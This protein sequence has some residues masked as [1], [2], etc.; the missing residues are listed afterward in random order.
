MQA[1]L[2]SVMCGTCAILACTT[3]ALAQNTAKDGPVLAARALE[4]TASFTFVLPA[5]SIRLVGWD[6]D[7]L[8]IRGS[9]KPHSFRYGAT[10]QGGK[11]FVEG[12]SQGTAEP[13]TVVVYFPRRGTVPVQTS[14]AEISATDLAGTFVSAT[15]SIRIAGEAS[16]VDV[17]AMSGNLDL[18]VSTPWLRARTGAGRLLV[19]G[20]P[21]DVDASTIG[22]ALDVATPAILRGRFASVTGDIRYASTPAPASLFDFSNHS[23]AIDFLLPQTA[24][25]RLDVSSITGAIENG[26]LQVRPAASGPHN[27]RLS[28]GRGESQITVR[29]FRGPV[30]LRPK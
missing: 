1:R 14:S 13:E 17:N 24:S 12:D 15:G 5:G 19:R 11:F 4:P 2:A 27:L 10:K 9:M 8:E 23:G 7:S 28:L 25:A 26:F 30:R 6:R 21:Q 3:G 29:S 22:G 18:E 16:S 20:A